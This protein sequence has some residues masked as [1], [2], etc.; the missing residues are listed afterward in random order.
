MSVWNY[1]CPNFCAA[2]QTYKHLVSRLKLQYFLFKCAEQVCWLIDL[3]IYIWNIKSNKWI[4]N[5][6]AKNE[7]RNFQ[8]HWEC[9]RY[10]FIQMLLINVCVMFSIVFE[11]HDCY[12]FGIILIF[13]IDRWINK[14]NNKLTVVYGQALWNWCIANICIE[15]E[16][17]FCTNAVDEVMRKSSPT[18]C[19]F[20]FAFVHFLWIWQHNIQYIYEKSYINT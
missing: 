6:H 3:W 18:S 13:W 2:R 1:L 15:N 19:R 20:V 7:W 5:L 14:E 17:L 4:S 9:I 10:K 8:E 11:I 16:K 12:Q